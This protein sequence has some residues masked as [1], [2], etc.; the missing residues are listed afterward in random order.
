MPMKIVIAGATGFIGAP[1]SELLIRSGHELTLLTR[2]IRPTASLSAR[3]RHV[4]WNP[5]D[6]TSIVEEVGACDAVINLAGE[7]V[8]NKRWTKSQKEKIL[9]SRVN[10]TQILVRSIQKAKTKP[11][12]L[13]NASAMGFYGPRGD[14]VVDETDHVG[15]DFLARV[16][17]AWE[18]HAIRAEDF[19]LRVVRLRIGVVLGKGGGALAK[20]LPPFNLFIG[21]W[22]GSGNQWLSWIHLEDAVRLIDFCLTNDR[23]RGAINLTAPE[24]VTNKQFSQALAR[25]LK[26][27]CVAPVPSLALKLLIGQMASEL[28]LKGQRVIPKKALEL[29]FSFRFPEIRSTLENLLGEVQH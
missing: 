11:N 4:A 6:E 26:R 16:C 14:E 13:I 7:S 9:T 17:K 12:V 24:P 20:I 28:L 29:G 22:L 15:D 10:A 23:A 19:N 1:L 25:T 21:G 18:A 27:P 2:R 3:V 5:E 8:A